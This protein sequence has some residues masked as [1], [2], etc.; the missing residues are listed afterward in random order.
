MM[1]ENNK[2]ILIL[3][4]SGF[5]GVECCEWEELYRRKQSYSDNPLNLD[6]Y[7][8]VILNVVSLYDNLF[9]FIGDLAEKIK[10]ELTSLLD[11]GGELIVLAC[12]KRTK[13]VDKD[14][15]LIDIDNYFWL[16]DDLPIEIVNKQGKNI[17]TTFEF[18]WAKEYRSFLKGYNFYI[19]AKTLQPILVI[20]DENGILIDRRRIE[21]IKKPRETLKLTIDGRKISIP[22]SEA[23]A[24]EINNSNK[25]L[26]MREI[27][28]IPLITTNS[29]APL[30]IK[31]QYY[32]YRLKPPS[33]NVIDRIYG[34][35]IILPAPT[36]KTIEEAISFILEE[37]LGVRTTTPP[38]EWTKDFNRYIP[39]LKKLEQEK[40]KV[41][42]EIEK[43]ERKKEE[44]E[45]EILAKKDYQK[46][47]YGTGTELEEIT[48][49]V[50]QEL[51]CKLREPESDEDLAIEFE[52]KRGIIECK[53]RTKDII[54]TNL[55]QLI[56]YSTEYKNKNQP[57]KAILIGN[58]WREE[59]PEN[60]G[61]IFSD[62][63]VKEAKKIGIALVSTVDLFYVF[64]RFL[65]GKVTPQQIMNKIFET[66][67]VVEFNGLINASG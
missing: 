19:N 64:C 34:E 11:N 45:R 18:P 3:G 13:K 49:K 63:A 56:Y 28:K 4:A 33:S 27:K 42:E 53:G 62:N 2:D 47:L 14:G 6:D 61:P 21:P 16:P 1:N 31:L 60:R 44:K 25:Q 48:R 59:H 36:E 8:L 39:E 17:K 46:L 7:K 67:G 43:S 37:I 54:P 23:L 10:E 20:T 65:E 5:A 30:S 32:Y 40:K 38:P 52:G 9:Y 50:F 22:I 12:P 26:W 15:N 35:F 51:G 29:N 24:N 57:V 66:D 41:E 58:G 55:R